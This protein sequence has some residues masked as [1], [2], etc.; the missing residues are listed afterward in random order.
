MEMRDHVTTLA[1]VPATWAE[2][3]GVQAQV[4]PFKRTL[5]VLNTPVPP[6]HTPRVLVAPVVPLPVGE[7]AAKRLQL[8]NTL[9]TAFAAENI[10]TDDADENEEDADAEVVADADAT[11]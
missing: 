4:A 9:S 10:E 11:D 5:H 7:L 2:A 8:A 1:T 3:A 6:E